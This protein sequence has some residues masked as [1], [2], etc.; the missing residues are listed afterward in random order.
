MKPTRDRGFA[1]LVVLWSLVLITLLTTQI[2]ASGRT[3]LTL[4]GN[5]RDAAEARASDDG[6]INEAIFHLL[7]SGADHWPADG[8][9][10]VLGTSD[11]TLTIRINSL[12]GKINPNLASTALLAA[13]FQACGAEPSQAK[14][15]AISIIAWRSIAISKSDTQALL[16]TYRRANLPYGPPGQPFADLSELADVI[17]MPPSLLVKGLPHM[18]LYQSGDPDPTLADPVVRQALGLSGQAGTNSKAYEG[19]FPVVSIDAQV[20][21]PGKLAVGRNAIVSLAGADAAP[22]FQVLSL[23]DDG[24]ATS[25]DIN[26]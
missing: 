13:L 1:L 12:A 26:P 22:P 9:P 8:S 7:S 15:L 23:S 14:Q 21:G 24:G 17:G 18:S 6:A 16:A 20:D 11:I 2:L 25:S 5:L 19:N 3:A 10:H 4:A